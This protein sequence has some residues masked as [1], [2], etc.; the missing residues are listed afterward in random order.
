MSKIDDLKLEI[1]RLPE[2]ELSELRRWLSEKH[3]ASWDEELAADSEAG[4]LDFLVQEVR[5]EKVKGNLK[6]L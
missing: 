1:E 3:W 5:E 6:D 2:K 4:R